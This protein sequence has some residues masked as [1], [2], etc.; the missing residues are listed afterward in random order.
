MNSL[1]P[2][3]MHNFQA[4][5]KSDACRSVL[6]PKGKL[7]HCWIPAPVST[8]LGGFP[9]SI[10][11]EPRLL[12]PFHDGT[13][14]S[15]AVGGGGDGDDEGEVEAVLLRPCPWTWWFLVGPLQ[16]PESRSDWNMS[17]NSCCSSSKLSCLCK[18][19]FYGHVTVIFH[20]YFGYIRSWKKMSISSL[21]P[22]KIT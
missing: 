2:D 22:G 13:A 17:T 16:N 20:I 10:A 19:K 6:T 3:L 8:G 15:V 18:P 4:I 9:E 21:V 11:D 7:L 12:K 5:Q 1:A 14:A